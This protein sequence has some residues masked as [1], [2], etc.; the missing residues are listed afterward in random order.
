MC[1]S[2]G[3][4]LGPTYVDVLCHGRTNETRTYVGTLLYI[5][6]ECARVDESRKCTYI[7]VRGGGEE[8]KGEVCMCVSKYISVESRSK[9]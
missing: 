3:H 6:D 9:R 4:A 5:V 1:H 8:G 7:Y 2:I